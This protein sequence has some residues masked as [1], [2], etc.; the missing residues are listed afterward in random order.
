[1]VD[2]LDVQLRN[3]EKRIFGEADVCG[4]FPSISESIE[5]LN[6]LVNATVA[7]KP[8][9]ET[10][11]KRVVELDKDLDL[12][13]IDQHAVSMETKLELLL[14]MKN[15]L[16]EQAATLERIES[17]CEVLGSEHIKV[18]PGQQTQLH[19]LS[20]INLQQEEEASNLDEESNTLIT[21]YN[22]LICS[23]SGQL[24]CWEAQLNK[25]EGAD[26][27]DVDVD[28]ETNKE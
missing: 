11:L 2:V 9:L 25:Y 16:L 22:S 3:L 1:M 26:D 10:L 12:D 23:L 7:G 17:M 4:E 24:A 15:M 8:N 28:E 18:I 20:S 5:S 6:S 14:P 13:H 21:Q 27:D 19:T